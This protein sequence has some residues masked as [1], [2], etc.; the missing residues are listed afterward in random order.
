MTW[1]ERYDAVA[2]DVE[3][4]ATHGKWGEL[5]G[6]FTY[7]KD[8]D[9]QTVKVIAWCRFFLPDLFTD[10][11]PEFHYELVKKYLSTEN[12]YIAAP[13]GYCRPEQALITMSNGFQKRMRDVVVGDKV[14]SLDEKTGRFVEDVVTDRFETGVKKCLLIETRSGRKEVCTSDHQILTF[15]GWKRAEEIT[16]KDYVVASRRE[17]M[18]VVDEGYSD[19]EV[20]LVA[21]LL[22]DGG[23]TASVMWSKSDPDLIA[24]MA[25]CTDEL[26][27]EMVHSDRVTWRVNGAKEWANRHEMLGKK[28]IDKNIPEWVFG[29]PERK[30]WMF[31]GACL[32]S[33]GYISLSGQVGIGLTNRGLING[34][35]FLLR[36][37][38]IIYTLRGKMTLSG[39]MSWVLTISGKEY[40]EKIRD[41]AQVRSGKFIR[42]LN[43]ILEKDRYSLIELFPNRIKKR[44]LNIDRLARDKGI[45]VDATKYEMTKDKLERLADAF[46][47]KVWD[48][49]LT[50]DVFLDKDYSS[51]QILNLLKIFGAELKQ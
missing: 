4:L 7:Y 8:I 50:G 34:L 18:N 44:V 12:E 40:L 6:Y 20:R 24:D 39:R 13:R 1:Q 31:L 22:M 23:L 15:D 14:L 42:K 9:E 30:V 10:D 45:R 48:E 11:T 35:A 28:S 32:C 38:G 33:D 37:V 51:S 3:L 41:N 49:Y 46:D 17:P 5:R 21:Y 25:H 47:T 36:R 2:G 26:G 19:E 16:I 29:L 27:F 43:T